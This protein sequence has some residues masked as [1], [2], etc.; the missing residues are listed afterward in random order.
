MVTFR[1][2]G[3]ISR[4]GANFGSSRRVFI[5]AAIGSAVGLGNIW[6]FP[7]VAY[8]NGGG[9]FILPYLV[10]LLTAALRYA[11][12]YA[13]AGL[14]Q[15]ILVQLRSDVYSKLQRLSFHFFDGNASSSII[16][17]AAGELHLSQPSLSRWL[18][19]LEH[20]VGEPL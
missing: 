16:N 17:R 11:A 10:A 18:A 9:A 2:S 8:E 14:T 7:Y 19:M 12:A 1:S 13:T 3:S 15:R 6:R 5:L 20:E 4:K